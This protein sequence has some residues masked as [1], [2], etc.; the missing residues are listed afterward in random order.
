MRVQDIMDR[1]HPWIYPDELATKARA[2]LRDSKLRILPVLG[3]TKLLLGVV[4]RND[5]MTISSSVSTVRVKGIMSAPKFV[6]TLDMDA[7][8]ATKAM[9]SADEW[10]VPVVKS[11]QDATYAG[12][13]GLEHVVR[14]LYEKKVARLNVQLAAIMSTKD[15]LVCAP[16]DEAD[17]VWR[18]MKER[19]F[20]ACPVVTKNKTIGIVTLQNLIESGATFPTFEAK[21][22]RFKAPSTIFTMMRTPVLSLKPSDTVGDAARL[23]LQK[24]IG[25]IPIVDEKRRLVG[26]VD[27]EDVLK[28]LIK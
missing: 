16:D 26:I 12:V 8:Q 25:R 6:A 17:N 24:N 11:Q 2:I 18:K 15:I 19:S 5:V 7:I 20:A 14:V 13:L 27:R 10:Y 1:N 4:S 28:A 23:M 9:F 22:G 3:D 21:K